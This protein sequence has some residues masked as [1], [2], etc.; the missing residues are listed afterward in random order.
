MKQYNKFKTKQK[1][2]P[3]KKLVKKLK[4]QYEL[5]LQNAFRKF[6]NR[7]KFTSEKTQVRI[8]M[9]LCNR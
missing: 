8:N 2:K 3:S 5:N 4:S 7:K 9:R 1:A 6:K